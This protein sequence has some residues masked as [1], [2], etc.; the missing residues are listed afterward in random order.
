MVKLW[1]ENNF[2][3]LNL[4]SVSLQAKFCHLSKFCHNIPFHLKS[5]GLAL[6]ISQSNQMPHYR[7]FDPPDHSDH[8]LLP[9]AIKNSPVA[10]ISNIASAISE[11]LYF[12]SLGIGVPDLYSLQLG[13]TSLSPLKCSGVQKLPNR[14][15][16]PS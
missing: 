3:K 8:N 14:V 6:V 1:P 13:Q 10:L 15:E 2:L 12:L 7:Y 4:F 5:T 9:G 11:G 16:Y